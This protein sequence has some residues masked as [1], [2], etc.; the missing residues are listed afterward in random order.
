MKNVFIYSLLFIIFIF[1]A[2][3]NEPVPIDVEADSMQW[4][5]ENRVAFA[6]GNAEAIQGDRNIKADK[7]IVYLNKEK[8]SNEVL[9]IEAE[10]NVVF[11]NNQ[12]IASG[13]EARYDLIK[14]NIILKNDVK[15]K[16]DE[17]IMAGQILEMDLETGIS[18]IKSKKENDRVRI[19][20]SPNEDKK[21]DE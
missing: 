9:L 6:I 13:Q 18:K 14:N 19:R 8:S 2:N 12:E 16:K 5:D 20:F 3:A 17:N 15:L 21:D 4:D 10:G 1:V 7:L 11:T